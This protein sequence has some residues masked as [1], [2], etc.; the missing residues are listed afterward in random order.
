M[1]RPN[2][3]HPYIRNSQLPSSRYSPT[4]SPRRPTR[5]T[6]IDIEQTKTV[7]QAYQ[8]IPPDYIRGMTT[9]GKSLI[10]KSIYQSPDGILHVQ[11]RLA[12][13]PSEYIP[14]LTPG[15]QYTSPFPSPMLLSQMDPALSG[16]GIKGQNTP[17]KDSAT[18]SSQD[19][20]SETCAG[21]ECTIVMDGE[22]EEE[23]DDD[24]AEGEVEEF[25][26]A[27]W[28]A[29]MEQRRISEGLAMERVQLQVRQ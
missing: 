29:L 1:P 16:M 13:F 17:R 14:C 19:G 12:P 27:K 28:R 7:A 25:D 20:N 26:E 6:P 9:D 11:M 10:A 15:R 24:D 4:S 21:E 8:Y 18:F 2:R 5:P 22:E 3:Y 23:D